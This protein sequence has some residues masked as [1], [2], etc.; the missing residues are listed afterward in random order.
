MNW[1]RS[2]WIVLLLLAPL[3]PAAESAAPLDGDSVIYPRNAPSA[4][5]VGATEESF[6]VWGVLAF[7]GVLAGGGFYLLRRGNLRGGQAAHVRQRLAIEETKALGNKQYLAVA[8]YGERK[9]LI[10]V[11][12][13]R[14]DLLTKLD[15]DAAPFRADFGE[16]SSA[17]VVAD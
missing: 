4:G 17:A 10:A 8:A 1:L 13:G 15:D 16:K 6:P 9:Y 12:P 11:C 14:I 7:A 2:G 5:T 3:V